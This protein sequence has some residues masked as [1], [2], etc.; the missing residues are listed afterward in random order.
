MCDL[1]DFVGKD[2]NDLCRSADGFKGRKVAALKVSVPMEVVAGSGHAEEPVD[3]FE[4]LM[5]TAALIMNSKRWGMGD[6]DVEGPSVVHF[7]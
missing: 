4:A 5:R 6:Q 2:I 3:S 7:V 1:K